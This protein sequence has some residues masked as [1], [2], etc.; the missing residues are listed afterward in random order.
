MKKKILIVSHSSVV[1]VYQDKLR[2]LARNSDFDVTLLI[3][4][5]YFEAGR[6]RDGFTGFGGYEVVK[7]PTLFGE[8]GRQ[9]L[10]VYLSLQRALNRI[11]PD[12]IHLEEEPFSMV[13][14]QIMYASGLLKKRP[15][16]VLF[17]WE[18]IDHDYS[19]LP[20]YAP[21]RHLY[22]RLQAY[23]L[24]NI[25]YM[26]YGNHEGQAIFER[27]GYTG[28]STIIPQYGVDPH[29]YNTSGD[30]PDELSTRLE[31]A[32]PIL[33]FVG[34][35]L[36]MKGIHNLLEA[37]AETTTGHLLMV[38]SGPDQGEF[39]KKV[40]SLGI[41]ERVTFTG[42]VEPKEVPDYLRLADILVLPSLTTPEWK[43]QFGR[44]LIE[45]M[46]CGT[47]PVGSS[48]GEIPT[49]I[50]D[51]GLV[52]KEGDSQDLLRQITSLMESPDLLASYKSAAIARVKKHYTNERIAA[53]LA[54]VYR[55]V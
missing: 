42:N 4:N 29:T 27:R 35:M 3:P 31:Q 16:F 10:H 53:Q 46:A 21:Q 28:P 52:F 54:D 38:G 33:L 6:V 39:E 1:D 34:R 45:A 32:G 30:I 40:G 36:R 50:G 11:Q 48:S 7:L 55:A 37:F 19:M 17:T 5:R 26:I 13:T 8:S 14:S 49:V 15:K 12:I 51:G 43:E 25:D 23:A 18:N 22:P 9:N 47:V 44:V 41:A 24:G 20:W 2:Y